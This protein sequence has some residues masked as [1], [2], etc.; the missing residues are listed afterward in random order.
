MKYLLLI[1]S[2]IIVGNL[3]SQPNQQLIP[4]YVLTGKSADELRL[5]RNEIYARHAYIFKSEDL[6]KYFSQKRWYKPEFDN[7]DLRLTSIDKQNL[8]RIKEFEEGVNIE[9][10]ELVYTDLAKAS[11]SRFKDKTYETILIKTREVSYHRNYE[12]GRIKKIMESSDYGGEGMP[13]VIY[14][15]TVDPSK[16]YWSTTK[17]FHDLTFHPNYY[18]ATLYGC[19]DTET[20]YEFYNYKS[21]VP[22][23]KSNEKY[24]NI[25]IPNTPIDLF[26][27][28]NHEIID[29]TKYIIAELTLSTLEGEINSVIFKT[30]NRQDFED[31][32]PYYTPSIE[33]KSKSAKDVIRDDEII[34]LWSLNFEKDL[35]AISGF[36]VKI[37]FSGWDTGKKATYEIPIKNGRL[38]GNQ[39]IIIDLK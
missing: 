10:Y 35:N 15:E 29:T 38:F 13:T 17:Y 9:N 18:L 21:E 11:I 31:I 4:D 39:T 27:G 30:N 28:Y 5:L 37:T 8:K 2:F 22:F 26:I 6:N 12:L 20:Y 25:E 32:M 33:L 36:S 1:L 34:T 16:P 24:F 7:I 19:C 14:A 23:L 3:Y